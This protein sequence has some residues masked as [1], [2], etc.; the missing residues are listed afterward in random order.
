MLKSQTKTLYL[1][2]WVALITF[3]FVTMI[4]TACS[5][6][7]LEGLENQPTA[8]AQSTTKSQPTPSPSPSSTPSPTATILPTFTPTPTPLPSETPTPS[9]TILP[10]P[11]IL[12]EE[13]SPN[14]EWQATVEQFGFEDSEAR[15]IFL[16][17]KHLQNGTEW[18][19][20][21]YKAEFFMDRRSPD[22]LYWSQDNQFLY[23]THNEFSDGCY[24]T[25]PH[26]DLQRLNL[27]TGAVNEI[28]APRIA[29]EY[30]FS[31]TEERI[32]LLL[33]DNAIAI[34][35]LTSDD[36]SEISFN[37]DPEPSDIHMSLVWSPN[38]DQIIA[39]LVFDLCRIP[40]GTEQSIIVLID[41]ETL[42]QTI[43][44][45]ND[46]SQI[47]PFSLVTWS[48]DDMVLLSKGGE[49][50]YMNPFTGELSDEP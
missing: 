30:I 6:N 43:L 46:G 23:F 3:V 36:T 25:G 49:E 4:V 7:A 41:L 50:W 44:L 29:Y 12:R 15:E 39:Q 2:R 18:I 1:L 11:Q 13:I 37:F 17:V 5:P 22:L 26:S 24:P 27:Q 20:D 16:R 42:E 21:R 32:A 8:V 45:E 19:I 35:D 31:P 40:L 33:N 9:P 48:E 10:T 38:G 14:E 47:P 34:Y 28:I